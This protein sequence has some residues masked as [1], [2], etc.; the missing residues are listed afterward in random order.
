MPKQGHFASVSQ[1]KRVNSF[2]VKRHEAEGTI[3][4]EQLTDF[5]VVRYALTVKKRIAPNHRETVQRF[6][7]E[8][9]DR[10]PQ[11][12]GNLA[13][14]I[15]TVLQELSPRVP[16]QFYWHLVAEWERLQVFLQKELP[17][18]PLAIRL[19]ITA[20]L[21]LAELQAQVAQVLAR[22]AAAI[23]F[24][25]SQQAAT[26]QSQLTQMLLATIFSKG[27]IDWEKVRALLAP[28]PFTIDP[29]LDQATQ[30]WL[31]QLRTE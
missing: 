22:Q 13:T 17:A 21:S 30:E 20:P 11:A 28:F 16:W 3:S 6:L 15:P 9:A 19:R 24:L 10:L 29:Q 31:A 8:L 4:E 23:T 12:K 2:K 14:L 18:V 1:R 26:K 5:L 25:Q 27:I 7:I